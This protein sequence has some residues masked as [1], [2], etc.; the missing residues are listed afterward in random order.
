MKNQAVSGF[1]GYQKEMQKSDSTLTSYRSDLMV[2]ARWFKNTNH[3][4]LTLS[5]ITPT[6]VR[7]YKRFLIDS[8]FKP[9]TIIRKL[10][11]IK[12]FLEWAWHTK[13]I[14]YRFPLPK[15]VKQAPSTPRWLTRIEQNALLR[16]VEQSGSVRNVAIIKVLMNTGLRVQELCHLKWRDITL[17][18][19]KGELIVRNSKGEEYR[20]IP[21][22]K[23]VRTAL[24]T[25][26]D[27]LHF[28]TDAFVFSGQRGP[29]TPRGVQLMMNRLFNNSTI[30]SI[31]PHQLRHTFC[32][33][34]IDAGIGL[35]KVAALAGH[36]RLNTIKVYCQ[37]SQSDLNN[38]VEQIGEKN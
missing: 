23:D 7:Q 37:P 31:S 22:N 32:K 34:L 5:K 33:N 4:T 13:R 24:I 20:K 1:I 3:E 18:K 2:F 6:D 9:N 16:Q 19:R 21:L 26:N 12:Y 14:K 30:D 27:E 15:L 10:L 17:N 36:E 25:L 11:S 28:G 38:A 8:D 29:L 35:E